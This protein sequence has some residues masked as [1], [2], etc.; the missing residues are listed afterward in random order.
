[1]R[2]LAVEPPVF[3]GPPSPLSEK[4]SRFSPT[5]DGVLE[6]T[7]P[8][9]MVVRVLVVLPLSRAKFVLNCQ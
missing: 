7:E 6:P 4:D 1:M 3:S 2:A 8:V 9:D 5:S